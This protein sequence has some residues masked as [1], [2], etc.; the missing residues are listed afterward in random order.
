MQ[1]RQKRNCLRA[2]ALASMVG[3]HFQKLDEFSLTLVLDS[4]VG[5]LE[6]LIK[7]LRTSYFLIFEPE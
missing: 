7:Y 3:S 1:S 2:N 4:D 5:G 6:G